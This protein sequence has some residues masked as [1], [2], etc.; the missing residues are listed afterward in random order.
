[1]SGIAYTRREGRYKTDRVT[2]RRVSRGEPCPLPDVY[3]RIIDEMT[4]SAIM[5]M[6]GAN[7]QSQAV[8]LAYKGPAR[9]YSG[10]G[11]YLLS[12]MVFCQHCHGTMMGHYRE[13]K[14]RGRERI[15]YYCYNATLQTDGIH[16]SRKI[17]DARILEE[18]VLRAVDPVTFE[19]IATHVSKPGY[20]APKRPRRSACQIQEETDR[21]IALVGRGILKEADFER[22]YVALQAELADLEVAES[23]REAK[24]MPEPAEL[25]AKLASGLSRLEQRAILRRLVRRVEYPLYINQVENSSRGRNLGTLRPCAKVWLIDQRGEEWPVVVPL[26]R[27]EYTGPRLRFLLVGGKV[28]IFN[29]GSDFANCGMTGAD[30]WC[31]DKQC[32]WGGCRKTSSE[33]PGC[34]TTTPS[35]GSEKTSSSRP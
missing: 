8:G 21:L 15:S 17:V 12:G 20:Q 11:T 26:Y 25:A 14:D 9:R 19:A 13:D 3:P 31:G 34:S 24:A 32:L 7:R 29:Y 4:E 30:K 10:K 18:A 5:A 6:Q 35:Q 2:G 33:G 23:A 1:M 27:T 28:S 22:R 16:H